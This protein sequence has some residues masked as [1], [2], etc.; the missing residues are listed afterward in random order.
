MWK[1]ETFYSC[2]TTDSENDE[3]W[4]AYEVNDNDEAVVDK[5]NNWLV[6][7]CGECTDLPEAQPLSSAPSDSNQ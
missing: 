3:P 6:D 4:C 2:T 5:D 7:D 1:N